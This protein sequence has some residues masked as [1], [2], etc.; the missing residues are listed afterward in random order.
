MID[1][2]LVTRKVLLI[3]KDLEELRMLVSGG[4]G[5]Y[6]S[7]PYKEVLAERF[8]ER[9][10]TRMIDVNYHLITGS[11]RAPPRDYYESFTELGKMGI[12]EPVFASK[13]ASSAGLRNRIVHEYDDIDP[14]KVFE[15]TQAALSDLPVY[16]KAILSFAG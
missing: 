7:D 10:I 13:I 16:L 12:L 15:A 2:E 5:E 14:A 8:L 3:G 9:T 6:L 4:L 11:G 1:R